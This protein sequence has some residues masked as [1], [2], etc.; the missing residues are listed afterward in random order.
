MN[1]LHLQYMLEVARCR[2]INQAAQNLIL[3]QPY[4]SSIIKKVEEDIGYQI[5]IRTSSGVKITEEGIEFLEYARQIERQIENI[6]A[7]KKK[8]EEKCTLSI[9]TVYSSVILQSFLDFQNIDRR[10]N[11]QDFIVEN[12]Q[13][14][15]IEQII[16]GEVRL[17]IIHGSKISDSYRN[18]YYQKYDLENITLLK[19]IP[20]KVIVY[21]GNPLSKWKSIH[22]SEIRNYPLVCYRN[23]KKEEFL[24]V[25][26]VSEKHD[27]LY[28]SDRGS[29]FD[30]IRSG[31]YISLT[32]EISHQQKRYSGCKCIPIEGS[33]LSVD[34]RY[35]KQKQY[36]L[37]ERE[38]EFLQFLKESI[39]REML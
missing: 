24:D 7:I 8:R 10:G 17:G 30:A 2:S 35:I 14:D 31:K 25:L 39:K 37:N 9:A 13:N 6:Y 21:E 26:N 29:F 11:S 20:I 3:S 22:L 27:I 16:S 18:P 32:M 36:H 33:K 1:T 12:N 15:I 5:F 4:L 23:T 28:V 38:K 34:I 19:N